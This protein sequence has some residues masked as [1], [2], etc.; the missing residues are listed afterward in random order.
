MRR[1]LCLDKQL[2]DSHRYQP[3]PVREE[4][5]LFRHLRYSVW[6]Y[7]VCAFSLDPTL[8]ESSFVSL[9]DDDLF[10]ILFFSRSIHILDRSLSKYCI[11]LLLHQ[12][13]LVR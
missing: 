6:M 8:I 5:A 4:E 7:S 9:K 2:F 13:C 10:P 3:R 1:I 11:K 12:I